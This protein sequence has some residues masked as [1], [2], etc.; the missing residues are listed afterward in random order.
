MNS[1]AAC[2]TRNIKRSIKNVLKTDL[3]NYNRL[4]THGRSH[5]KFQAEQTETV[6]TFSD[7][8]YRSPHIIQDRIISSILLISSMSLHSS[9]LTFSKNPE[10]AESGLAPPPPPRGHPQE[11]VRKFQIL[12]NLQLN[13]INL[14]KLTAKPKMDGA[15]SSETS[16]TT[17]QIKRR[18]IPED[19]SYCN[20]SLKFCEDNVIP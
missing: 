4:H 15:S 10:E 13:S 9:I 6:V 19:G 18:H 16:V 7:Y 3:H 20:E 17:Y 11:Y 8:L 12:N 14:E 1:T 2:F 5:A